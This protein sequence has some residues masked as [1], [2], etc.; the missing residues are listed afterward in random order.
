MYGAL[1]TALVLLF[2]LYLLARLMVGSAVL[3]AELA[4]RHER[5]EAD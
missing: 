3:N 4:A 1:G 2:W 5:A